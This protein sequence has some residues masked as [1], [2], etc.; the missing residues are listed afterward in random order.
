M[1]AGRARKHLLTYDRLLL[2]GADKLLEADTLEVFQH[3]RRNGHHPTRLVVIALSFR[4]RT[5]LGIVPELWG[6]CVV[7]RHIEFE[8]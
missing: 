7:I 8:S 5:H 4:S 1:H 3:L 2:E 6:D